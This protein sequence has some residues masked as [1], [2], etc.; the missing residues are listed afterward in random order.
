MSVRLFAAALL[1]CAAMPATAETVAIVNADI[2]TMGP[3][4]EIARGTIVVRDGIIIAVGDKVTPPA[5]A[6]IVD[7]KGGVVT[8]GLVAPI[9]NLG[10]VEIRSIAGS[11]DRGAANPQISAALDAGDGLN[12]DSVLIPVARLGGITRS[13]TVPGYARRGDNLF[14]GQAAAVQLGVDGPMLV[15]RGVAMV[16]EL[17]EGGAERAGGARGAAMRML[18]TVLDDARDHARRR[19]GYDLGQ[20]R[21]YALSG[22]DLDALL[23]VAEGR[24]PLLVTVN[25]ASDIRELLAF[26]KAQHLR[27]IIE[28]AAEGWRVADEIAA[29][30]VPVVLTPIKNVPAS[31]EMLGATLGNATKLR[32]AGVLIAFEGNGPQRERELRHNAGNVVAYGLSRADALAAITINPA[33]IFGLADRIGSLEPG[34]DGDLVIW[35]GDPLETTSR[36]QAIFVRGVAQP[37]TSRQTELRDRYLPGRKPS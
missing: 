22:A 31:F 10:L 32:A 33:R 25:R 5:G 4:G 6:R 36:P 34:K 24:M 18:T 11:D 23:P 3:G 19:S 2:V 1:A 12:P 17:G 20:T 27:L 14:A 35:D 30:K 15:R 13:I 7:A 21:H 37:M 26:A 9:T 16:L 8:P 29:A 28:G